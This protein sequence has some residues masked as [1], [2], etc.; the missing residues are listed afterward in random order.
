MS[1]HF[2][3]LNSS[4]AEAILAGTPHQ[5][6]TSVI[7]SITFSGQ[8]FHSQHHLSTWV[9]QWTLIW[10]LRL[11][12]NICS[13][14]PSSILGISLD[15]VLCSLLQMQK[16]LS[17]P[18]S[19]PGWTTVM[20]FSSG[21]LAK[22]YRNCSTFRT[23]LLGSW[24][25]YANTIISPP[26]LKSLH[27]LPVSFRIVYKVSLL[28]HQCIHGDTPSYLKELLTPQISKRT[29]RSASTYLLKPPRTKLRTMGDR[30]FCSAA[31]S[32]WNALPDHLE[33]PQT[34]DAFKRGLKT[35]LFSKV[36]EWFLTFI[37]VFN[38]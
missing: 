14:L 7:S 2:L 28:T 5:V 30:A 20:R 21:S 25:G 24:C 19:P 17:M 27:W 10:L 8:T 31:Q 12:L 6:Q 26:I 9:L 4:K 38:L 35:Y 32:L 18:L 22:A 33:T 1:Q 11:T 3:H 13:R 29:L 36:F 34:V 23:V 15:F 37:F 16:S